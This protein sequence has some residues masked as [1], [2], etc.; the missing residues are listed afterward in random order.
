MKPLKI[1]F[2]VFLFISCSSLNKTNKILSASDAVLAKI[3]L[4]ESQVK[5]YQNDKKADFIKEV[6]EIVNL[7]G[8]A[9]TE[10]HY[11]G[12]DYII[13][14]PTN[15]NIDSWKEWYLNYK[16]E[17]YYSPNNSCLINLNISEP[18]RKEVIFIKTKLGEMKNSLT[19]NQELLCKNK[20]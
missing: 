1:I 15:E 20:D 11:T 6:N 17:F 9:P 16:N 5:L 19:S 3:E 13:Y 12:S 7:S 4:I 8:I 2:I 14:I 10:K 18:V